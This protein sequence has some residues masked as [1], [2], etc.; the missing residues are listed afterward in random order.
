MAKGSTVCSTRALY[1]SCFN[2]DLRMEINYVL[3]DNYPMN[4]AILK[5]GALPLRKYRIYEIPIP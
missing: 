2:P 3:E 4:N 1:E 5:L